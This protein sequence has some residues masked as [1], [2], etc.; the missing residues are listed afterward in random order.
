MAAKVPKGAL[1]HV[2]AAAE[3]GAAE[4]LGVVRI[5]VNEARAGLRA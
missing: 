4:G 5:E 1:I 2:A 3:H